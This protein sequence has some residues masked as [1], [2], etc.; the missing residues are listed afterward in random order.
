MGQR[1]EFLS[2]SF[3]DVL[4]P[5]EIVL[6]WGS[7][8]HHSDTKRCRIVTKNHL[9]FECW[10]CNLVV[11]LHSISLFCDKVT[12]E[13]SRT[14]SQIEVAQNIPRLLDTSQLDWPLKPTVRIPVGYG[15]FR[16]LWGDSR[17]CLWCFRMFSK[18]PNDP[19]L[20]TL[21]FDHSDL[22]CGTPYPHLHGPQE[23][24]HYQEHDNIS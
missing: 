10:S 21:V 24:R 14:A 15:W 17:T 3:W 18:I 6:G 13:P 2:G 12:I 9:V 4:S 22:M 16:W 11:F 1:I 5:S 7:W 23:F 8:I 20:H 19:V